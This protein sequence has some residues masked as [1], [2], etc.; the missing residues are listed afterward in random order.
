M[1]PDFKSCSQISF[2]GQHPCPGHFTAAKTATDR[3]SALLAR[4]IFEID[5][6]SFKVTKADEYAIF[7]NKHKISASGTPAGGIPVD[8]EILIV[9]EYAR[10]QHVES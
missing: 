4:I 3:K 8:V 2:Q 9:W 7:Q 1:F 6:N 10:F 5:S